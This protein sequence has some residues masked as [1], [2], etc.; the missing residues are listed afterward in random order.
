MALVDAEYCFMFAD[1]GCQ[2]RL[3]DGAVFKNTVLYN[4]IKSKSLNLPNDEPLP[5]RQKLMP[6]VFLGDDAFALS[7][8]LM[9]PFPGSH[10]QGSKPRIFNYRLSRA[11]RIV[12]N[13]FGIMASVFRVLRKPMLLQPDK[14]ALVTMTC[15]ILHN[16]LRRSRTSRSMYTPA[17]TFDSEDNGMVTGGSWRED[18]ADMTSMLPLQKVPRKPGTAAKEYREEFAEYFMNNG[19][20]PWQN[21][22]S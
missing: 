4:K 15:V 6:Y 11:R 8:R 7:K 12:E 21:D 16:F 19:K 14:V 3:S 1:C 17:G 10:E 9:K 2:G 13:T 18:T 22:Y 20:I 5:G